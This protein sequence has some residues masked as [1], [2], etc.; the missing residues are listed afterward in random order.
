[1]NMK[2]KQEEADAHQ[3]CFPL[4]SHRLH[5]ESRQK[6]IDAAQKYRKSSTG[7][8]FT[9]GEFSWMHVGDRQPCFMLEYNKNAISW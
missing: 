8:G 9:G 3:F 1:M 6:F 2:K 7:E 5:L 4:N